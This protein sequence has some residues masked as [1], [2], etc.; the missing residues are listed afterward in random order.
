MGRPEAVPRLHPHEVAQGAFAAGLAGW[1]LVQAGPRA[2][3]TQL[4]A[5]IACA[6]VAGVLLLARASSER[7]Q[8][9]RLASAYLLGLVSFRCIAF[10]I[11]ALGL[12]LRDA[13]LL[14]IDRTI[15]GE[16]PALS[17]RPFSRPWLT[18]VMSAFYLS[19]HLYFC[20]L[21][22]HALFLPLSRAGRSFASLFTALPL[23]LV[24]YLA[25][26]AVGP[27]VALREEIGALTAG[28]VTAIC[29]SLV[30]RAGA[31]YDAFPSLHI[32]LTL[33]MLD[34]DRQFHP[35][36]FRL[37]WPVAIGLFVSTLYLHYHYAVDLLG[38]VVW[39]AAHKAWWLWRERGAT[40]ASSPP[41]MDLGRGERG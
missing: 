31:V 30:E 35:R 10:A 18:E 33:V 12:P 40:G 29:T 36:R 6:Q 39:F 11:P 17:W 13:A 22:I 32:F 25:V 9:V 28:P 20:G 37:C 19:Y 27:R 34:H 26:P 41:F 1:L 5:A 16:T 38:G 2:P 23:G 15:L 24:G 14:A 4:Y 21:L 3:A 8:K 7:W